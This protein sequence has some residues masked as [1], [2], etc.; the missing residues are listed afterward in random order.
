MGIRY[1]GTS[2]FLLWNKFITFSIM[3][4]KQMKINN[5]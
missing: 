3:A 2:F 4:M 5:W 1:M